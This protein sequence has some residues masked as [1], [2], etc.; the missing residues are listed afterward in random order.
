MWVPQ[1]T[2]TNPK[3]LYKNSRN[4]LYLRLVWSPAK[5]LTLLH[6]MFPWKEPSV[7]SPAM[8]NEQRHYHFG[9]KSTTSGARLGQSSGFSN[10]FTG[11][12]W[13]SFPSPFSYP[14]AME[15]TW[16]RWCSCGRCLAWLKSGY[17]EYCISTPKRFNFDPNNC[18]GIFSF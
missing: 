9:G 16:T 12:I 4:S 10:S 6:W 11:S 7:P 15:R 2:A 13:P 1:A 14:P 5:N 8:Q 17:G 3:Q 18:T